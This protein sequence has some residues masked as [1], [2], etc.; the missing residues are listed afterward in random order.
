MLADMLGV[1]LRTEQACKQTGNDAVLLV[2]RCLHQIAANA[3]FL[4]KQA[5]AR[6]PARVI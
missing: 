4:A 2:A 6:R 5:K 3:R 1:I